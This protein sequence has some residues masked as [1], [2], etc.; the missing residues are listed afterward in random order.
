MTAR[1]HR[2]TA[3]AT[4]ALAALLLGGALGS[5]QAHE[6]TRGQR[7]GRPAAQQ[8]IR[9]AGHRHDGHRRHQRDWRDHGWHVQQPRR[10]WKRHGHG[11]WRHHGPHWKHHRHHG[12]G[13]HGRY[14]AYPYGYWR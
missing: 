10:H 9:D 8:D 1:P 7:D 12:R 13:H 5:A 14:W 2:I 3:L 4:A 6:G 11:H